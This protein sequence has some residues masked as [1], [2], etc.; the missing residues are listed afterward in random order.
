[1]K[2]DDTDRTSWSY[3]VYDTRP[4]QKH[5]P[6]ASIRVF[7]LMQCY[8]LFSKELTQVISALKSI[9]TYSTMLTL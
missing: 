6:I 3:V 2:Y 8:S 4:K 9:S 5:P 1:M 7:L